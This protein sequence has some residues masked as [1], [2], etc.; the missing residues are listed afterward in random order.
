MDRRQTRKK[1]YHHGD[2]RNA[3]IETGTQLLREQGVGGLSLRAA[4]HRAGVS[5]AAPYRHFRDKAALLAAIAALGF[6]ELAAALN[7]TAARYPDDPATQLVEAGVAYVLLAV[8]NPQ[9]A[10]LMFGSVNLDAD[11][12]SLRQAGPNAFDALVGIIEN[13]LQA[14]IYADGDARDLARSAW[15]LVHGLATLIIAGRLEDVASEKQ[16]I[17]V[18]RGSCRIY[19]SG[20]LKRSG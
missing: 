6:D 8:R 17:E 19:Q 2:L 16:V 15:A 7:D 1:S 20:L 3:L 14:G 13:G 11:D 18:T 10:K 4:A 5:H 9:R 12:E